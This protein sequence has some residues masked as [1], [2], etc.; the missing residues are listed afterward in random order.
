MMLSRYGIIAGPSSGEALHGLLAYLDKVKVEG[1]LSELA[2][3]S[4]NE[5]PCVFVCA[6]LPYQYMDLY[7]SKL[8]EDEFPPI[9]NQVGEGLLYNKCPV[10]IAQNLLQCDQDPYDE[11]WFLLHNQALDLLTQHCLEGVSLC[12]TPLS[13]LCTM[14]VLSQVSTPSS[15]SSLV[16]DTSS[17]DS[18][19][20]TSSIFSTPFC[21]E[22]TAS[23]SIAVTILDLRSHELYVS[24]HIRNSRNVPLP[25]TQED[26]FGDAKLVEQ[27]WI[28][29]N[30]AL[31][32]NVWTWRVDGK[33]L[34]LCD[35]GDSSKMA[36]AML[37]ARGCEALC[38]EG[39]YRMLLGR[40]RSFE[41][42]LDVD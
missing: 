12:A 28:Q 4:T 23:K 21:P 29:L 16:S 32:S 7:Y 15:I 40:L 26:F 22:Q 18:I 35:D 39:G 33:V 30:A 8:R 9:H 37:R 3:P 13:C 10:D 36:T 14:Q 25:P 2:D 24:S 31:E 19:D 1:R 5:I 11:R 42:D 6:D 17:V 27:R 34:V 41:G 20:S 38:I